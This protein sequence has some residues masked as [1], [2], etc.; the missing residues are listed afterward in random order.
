MPL[1]PESLPIISHILQNKSWQSF[2]LK[3]MTSFISQCYTAGLSLQSDTDLEQTYSTPDCSISKDEW[4]DFYEDLQEILPFKHNY[5]NSSP[6]E[7]DQHDT[8]E[9]DSCTLLTDIIVDLSEGARLYEH[10]QNEALFHWQMTFEISWG[11]K[12]LVLLRAL[13]HYIIEETL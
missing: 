9:Y 4:L 13:H 1:S 7:T 3:E 12:S 11:E 10:N 5:A 6:F 8:E 2:S